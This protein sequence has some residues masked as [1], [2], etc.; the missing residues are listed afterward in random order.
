MTRHARTGF[1]RCGTSLPQLSSGPLGWRHQASFFLNQDS[2]MKLAL[3][4]I[5][6][7]ALNGCTTYYIP[8]DSFLH[9]FNGIDSTKMRRVK[10]NVPSLLFGT[11]MI[12]YLANPIDTI[13]CVDNNN[14]PVKLANSPSIEI[15]FTDKNDDRTIFYF[16]TICLQDSVILGDRSRYLPLLHDEILLNNVK[17]IEVQDGKKNF[18]YVKDEK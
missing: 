16:D 9:Q 8:R 13:D 6:M 10:A 15:R 3:L 17:L 18:H 5:L 7:L 1:R 4:L 14:K 2:T 12:S 11:T